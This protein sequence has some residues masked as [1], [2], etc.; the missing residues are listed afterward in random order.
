M[1]SAS[2]ASSAPPISSCQAVKLARDISGGR[3]QRLIRMPPS[4]P[5][6]TLQSAA[7]TPV[8]SMPASARRITRVT[9]TA[10]IRIETI[11]IRVGGW[12]SRAQASRMVI[13]G[14]SVWKVPATPPGSRMAETN[15]REKKAPKFNVPSTI[16]FGQ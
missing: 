12:R 7:A 4:E 3:P 16:S 10:P 11:F 1:I 8:M 2:T 13:S 6:T 15:S 5:A 9:P 14:P